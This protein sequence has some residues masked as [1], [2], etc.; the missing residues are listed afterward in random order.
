M[1]TAGLEFLCFSRQEEWPVSQVN[2]VVLQVSIR[3][4]KELHGH[5]ATFLLLG[6]VDDP[7][8]QATLHALQRDGQEG[9]VKAGVVPAA[10]AEGGGG[11]AVGVLWDQAHPFLLIHCYIS[12]PSTNPGMWWLI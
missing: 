4:L 9:T 2:I 12:M 1:A 11:H 6:A 7:I 5:K 8:H 3:V 10:E